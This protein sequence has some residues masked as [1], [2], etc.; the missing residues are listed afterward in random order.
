VTVDDAFAILLAH[1]RRTNTH[2]IEAAQSAVTDPAYLAA[3]SDPLPD[4]AGPAPGPAADGR[5]PTETVAAA[6]SRRGEDLE[7]LLGRADV[8]DSAAERRDR[9]ADERVG[10]ETEDQSRLD[11]I[12]AGR[13]RDS[14]MG[15]RADLMDLLNDEV[16]PPPVNDEDRPPPVND[17][18]RPPP[19]NENDRPPADR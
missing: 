10:P 1:A 9:D 4:P 15:D 11:R 6:K 12:W 2:L 18:D 16:R 14:S 13:D 3:L 8:R 17:E 19:V 5:R 7:A